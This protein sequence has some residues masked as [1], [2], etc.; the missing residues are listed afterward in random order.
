MATPLPTYQTTWDIA[1]NV[2][3]TIRTSTDPEE[4]AQAATRLAAL[5][6]MVIANPHLA[7]AYR[8]GMTRA[9]DE[10]GDGA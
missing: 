1:Y 8:R 10:T 7:L 5:N 2:M 4:L 9:M 3:T 6:A